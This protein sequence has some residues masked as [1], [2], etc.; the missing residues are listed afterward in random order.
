MIDMGGL[1]VCKKKTV[2][3]PKHFENRSHYEKTLECAEMTSQ[4]HDLSEHSVISKQLRIF[5]WQLR[6][7]ECKFAR[8]ADIV[9]K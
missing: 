6:L 1:L 2:F 8:I 3:F 9:Y 7:Y 5:Y 4:S